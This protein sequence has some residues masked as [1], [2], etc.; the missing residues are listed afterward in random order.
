MK[1]VFLFCA[2]AVITTA[3]RA[4]TKISDVV[5]FSSE[6]ISLGKIK[7]DQ[8]A[9]ATF[10]ITNISTKPVLI[11]EAEPSCGC[12]IA[13]YTTTPIAPGEKG[14]IQATYNAA[15]EGIFAKSVTVK[16]AS[17][18]ET[19]TLKLSGEVVAAKDQGN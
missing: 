9:I 1:K 5:K 10:E 19:A 17:I 18:D 11:E 6:S 14:F 13:N 8:P 3:A 4:Q 2:I 7:Q 15:G 12:T 16:F